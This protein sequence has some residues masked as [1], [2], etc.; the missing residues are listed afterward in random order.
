MHVLLDMTFNKRQQA[1][2]SSFKLYERKTHK[3]FHCGEVDLNPVSQSVAALSREKSAPHK[4]Y[5]LIPHPHPSQE[6]K[7]YALV[8][9]IRAPNQILQLFKMP[10]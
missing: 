3:Q 10:Y 8:V 7:D 5:V 6:V 4:H 9:V 1:Q 2:K